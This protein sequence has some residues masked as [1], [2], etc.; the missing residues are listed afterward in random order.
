M[1]AVG[2]KTL[3][4]FV[5]LIGLAA[6]A[7]RDADV[8]T[9]RLATERGDIVIDL[10]TEKAPA[11]AANFLAHVD[12]G[13]FEGAAF[14]R[15]TR[16]DNDP[17]IEVVQAGLWDPKREGAPGYEFKPPLAP[18]AHETT[19]LSGLAHED[20]VVSMAR[21]EPGSATSEFFIS[22]GD[23]P[24]LDFGG[25]RNPDGQG[26]AAFGRVRDGIEVVRAIHQAETESGEGF[27]GQLLKAPVKILSARRED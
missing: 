22:I 8:V 3:A 2:V 19:A 15:T 14:Y 17:M 21:V 7:R 24:E 18:I 23:N 9:V 25:A 6:C 11:T 12:A 13:L 16:P 5:V 26:F 10:Y 1:R 20:G 4:L 27:E